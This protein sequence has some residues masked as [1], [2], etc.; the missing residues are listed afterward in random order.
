MNT[1]SNKLK[2]SIEYCVPCDYSDY[3]LK[4]TRAI[5]KN[6]QHDIEQLTLIPGTKGIFD[7]KVNNELIFSKKE[8]N[9]YPENGEIAILIKEKMVS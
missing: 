9:R 6:F 5:I 4:E 1:I 2:V 7:I 8:L 3:A